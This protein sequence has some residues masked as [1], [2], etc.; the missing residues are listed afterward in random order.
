MMWLERAYEQR[1]SGLVSIKM[2]WMFDPLRKPKRFGALLRRMN[3]GE[4]S[5]P[6]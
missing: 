3:L 4:G 2:N 5:R 1:S 6:F